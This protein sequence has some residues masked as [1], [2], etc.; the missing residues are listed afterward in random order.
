MRVMIRGNPTQSDA[1]QCDSARSGAAG[2]VLVL[3]DDDIVHL[4]DG[5]YGVFRLDRSGAATPGAEPKAVVR[6]L[7]VSAPPPT[8][9][10]P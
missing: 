5:A 1:I 2:Q 4:A 6:A 9:L 3:E 10:D 7:Q 8:T